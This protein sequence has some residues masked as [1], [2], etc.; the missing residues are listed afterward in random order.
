MSPDE[1][2]MELKA[3]YQAEADSSIANGGSH[4]EAKKEY[5]TM[6]RAFKEKQRGREQSI[7]PKDTLSER[8]KEL[9]SLMA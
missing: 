2:Y 6:L 3:I 1:I 8:V 4:L 9:Y 5:Q 7:H